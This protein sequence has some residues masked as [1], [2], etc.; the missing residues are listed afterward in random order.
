MTL[1]AGRLTESV[2]DLPLPTDTRSCLC[3]CVRRLEM[4]QRGCAPGTSAENRGIKRKVV[5]WSEISASS[6][7]LAPKM[8]STRLMLIG[9]KVRSGFSIVSYR[10]TWMSFWAN[11]IPQQSWSDRKM[12]SQRQP[13]ACAL[14][15]ELREGHAPS[16]QPWLRWPPGTFHKCPEEMSK[17]RPQ[18]H[19]ICEE[20]ATS[21]SS[22]Q[23]WDTTGE[24]GNAW[25]RSKGGMAQSRPNHLHISAGQTHQPSRRRGTSS[26]ALERM[27]LLTVTWPQGHTGL[28]KPIYSTSKVVPQES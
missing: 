28:S 27:A 19:N 25:L 16:S 21:P 18:G 5:F 7:H 6:F 3:P 2:P 4:R 13:R 1:K 14:P 23:Q 12:A 15:S 24:L 11:P 9:Q 26:E 17:A 20:W 8:L 10:K 22:G